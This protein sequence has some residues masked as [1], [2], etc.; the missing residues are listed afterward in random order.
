MFLRG[1]VCLFFLN[2]FFGLVSLLEKG[3]MITCAGFIF[4]QS[5]F[6]L[7]TSSFSELKGAYIRIVG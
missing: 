4:G 2:E 5:F 3:L 1:R 6:K 7:S